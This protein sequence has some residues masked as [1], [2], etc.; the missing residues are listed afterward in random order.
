MQMSRCPAFTGPRLLV[1]VRDAEE[2]RAALRGGAD[3]IDV[4]DPDAGALGRPSDATVATVLALV[5]GRCAVT[6]ALGE[7]GE[8]ADGV[9][10]DGHGTQGA[11]GGWPASG[12]RSAEPGPC[13]QPSLFKLGLAHA[14]RHWRTR[15]DALARELG[16]DRFVITAYA[17]ADRVAAPPLEELMAWAQPARVAGLLIDT[18]V[19]DGRGLFDWLDERTLCDAIDQARTAGLMIALAGSLTLDAVTRCAALRPD[20]VA[21]RSAACAGGDR[22]GQVTSAAVCAVRAALATGVA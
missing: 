18:A 2:A 14:P 10:S 11:T 20:V 4:K 22:G 7:I 13:R 12:T 8:H 5:A 3:V 16:R 9:L 15:L 19:K 21:V 6:A 1:S 17:D